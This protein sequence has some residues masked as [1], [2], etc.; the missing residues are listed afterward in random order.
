MEEIRLP[1]TSCRLKSSFEET[2]ITQ[3]EAGTFNPAEGVVEIAC[4]VPLKAH[5]HF[6]DARNAV[7]DVSIH[8]IPDDHSEENLECSIFEYSGSRLIRVIAGEKSSDAQKPRVYWDRLFIDE[9][10]LTSLS[11][12]CSLPKNINLSHIRKKVF[13]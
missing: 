8:Y 12:I 11:I 3:N 13:F 4:P 2:P 1:A 6:S 9:S 10:S 5:D 7:T